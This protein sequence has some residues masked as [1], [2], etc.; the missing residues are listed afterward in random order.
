[1]LHRIAPRG[2]HRIAAAYITQINEPVLLCGLHNA[3]STRDM[4]PKSTKITFVDKLGNVI[5]PEGSLAPS[6]NEQ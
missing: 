2:L 1:L 3:A 6:E 4:P 5:L